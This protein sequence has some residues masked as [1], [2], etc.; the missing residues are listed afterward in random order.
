M[1]AQL[2]RAD[3]EGHPG[4]GVALG[5][6]H[7]QRLPGQRLLL[8]VASLHPLG[9][10]EYG[11]QLRFGE[12]GYGEEV[13]RQSICSWVS[14][15]SCR[16]CRS[17]WYPPPAAM[18]IADAL[19]GAKSG[20]RREVDPAGDRSGGMA[21]T[22]SVRPPPAPVTQRPCSAGPGRPASSPPDRAAPASRT[23]T[24]TAA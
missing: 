23:D 18:A 17:Q 1:P 3:L 2:E 16:V 21:S 7:P 13:T 15:V 6:D 14:G 24:G 10:S 11:E 4:P 20:D 8:V 22:R 5:E 9:E 12:V 19:P